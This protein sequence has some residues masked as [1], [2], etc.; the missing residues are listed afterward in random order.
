MAP[1]RGL[2]ADLRPAVECE[3]KGARGVVKGWRKSLDKADESV[4]RA[5]RTVTPIFS[6]YDQ[7]AAMNR[8]YQADRIR[9]RM[10]GVQI[11]AAIA[12]TERELASMSRRLNERYQPIDSV[13][14][15][16]AVDAA[17]HPVMRPVVEDD[18]QRVMMLR[19]QVLKQR[20]DINFRKL[21]KILPD[22]KGI[23][24]SDPQNGNVLA[25]FMKALAEAAQAGHGEGPERIA[26]GGANGTTGGDAG[27]DERE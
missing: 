26:H 16:P 24:L 20:S 13:T 11:I 19:L 14:Q 10:S 17:G 12:K 5:P 27:A 22:L 25:P 6:R 8:A 23:E 21:A 15:K 18:E 7:R 2:D 1:D 4:A 9:Q 3:P